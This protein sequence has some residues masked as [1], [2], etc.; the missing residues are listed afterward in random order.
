MPDDLPE[1][2]FATQADFEAWL[3]EE[4]ATTPGVWIRVAKARSGI[5]GITPAEAIE[6]CL[7]FGWID[8]QRMPRDDTTYL[9]RYTPRRSRS[10]W[11]KINRERASGLL[12]EGRMRPAGLAE[13]R[14]AQ[15]DGRWDAAYD[16][17]RTMQ[18]P[19][20]LQR[21]LDAEP[22]AKAEFA[23]LDATNRYAILFRI[24]D[25]KRPET[26][27]RRIETFVDMLARGERLHPPRK[28]STG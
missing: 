25:A 17:A 13:I 23:E 16:S 28:R 19:D 6:S 11:S 1:L 9:Q 4:H 22:R 20:D 7:C 10:K 18:V 14:R 21:A 12:A 8:S 27:A 26:R 3:E 5:A 2:V 24:H 15:E